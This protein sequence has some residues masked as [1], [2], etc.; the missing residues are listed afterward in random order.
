M[1][2]AQILPNLPRA[3]KLLFVRLRSLGDTLL[4]TPLYAALKGWRPD[5][6]ISALVESPY[7]EVVRNNPDLDEVLSLPAVHEQ[8][9]PKWLARWKTLQQIR[10]RRFDCCINLH[11]G[12]T[13]GLLTGL[14]GSAYRVGHRGFRNN[15]C[16]NVRINLPPQLEKE[17]RQHTVEYQMDWLYALGMPHGDIPPLKLVPDPSWEIPTTS[18]LTEAGIDLSSPYAVIQPTSKFATKEWTPQGFAEVSDSLKLARGWQTVLTGGPGEEQ[19][20]RE[21]SDLCRFRP[22]KLIDLSLSEL[23]WVIRRARC[24]IGNDSGPA[25]LAAALQIPLVVLFGS[26]DS[27]VWYPWKARH[28]LVQNRFDCN[29]CPGYRCLVYDEPKCILS[30]TTSQVKSALEKLLEKFPG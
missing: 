6:R 26:S 11:G 9:Y 24:F 20:L 19:R 14:S 17:N 3:A 23:T 22:A 21:V 4:S 12:S 8:K 1:N 15:F 28:V 13:S 30:I 18:K 2:T 16:Y 25:H 10:W 29:P 5:L 27:Q 7:D